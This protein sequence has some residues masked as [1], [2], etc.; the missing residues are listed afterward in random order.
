MKKIV[1]F[2]FVFLIMIPVLSIS[3]SAGGGGS[4]FVT[5][6]NYVYSD[7]FD[8]NTLSGGGT[9]LKT[10]SVDSKLLNSNNSLN[11]EKMLWAQA[12][13]SCSFDSKSYKE[14]ERSYCKDG[15][16]S[17]CF[18]PYAFMFD[19]V[20]T[21]TAYLFEFHNDYVRFLSALYANNYNGFKIYADGKPF[22]YLAFNYRTTSKS[23][24]R[25]RYNYFTCVYYS[26][27]KFSL[28]KKDDYYT[29]ENPDTS[30]PVY[31]L[32]SSYREDLYTVNPDQKYTVSSPSR[33]LTIIKEKNFARF[34]QNNFSSIISTGSSSNISESDYLCTKE[35]FEVES[36]YSNFDFGEGLFSDCEVHCKGSV[37]N[38]NMFPGDL[39]NKIDVKFEPELKLNMD[40]LNE[41]DE[42]VKFTVTNH[43]DK[44]VQFCMYIDGMDNEDEYFSLTDAGTG[45][46]I[47]DK[48]K[49]LKKFAYQK[50]LWNYK[51]ENYYYELDVHDNSKLLGISVA[52]ELVPTKVQGST[53]WIYLK[54]NE[55]YSD[56]I[57][58]ANV[59]LA[60]GVKY[61]M[62][63]KAFEVPDTLDIATNIIYDS[64]VITD[65]RY[66]EGVVNGGLNRKPW[67]MPF[68]SSI[69]ANDKL[70][71]YMLSPDDLATVYQKEIS[72]VTIPEF[73]DT[74]IG[75]SGTLSNGYLN[76]I[77]EFSKYNYKKDLTTGVEEFGS[78]VSGGTQ[79][80]DIENVQ[81]GDVI[82]YL[83]YC[84]SFFVLLKAAFMC[85]PAYIWVM[86]YFGLTAVVVIGIVKAVL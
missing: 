44:A 12:L 36:I 52:N 43:S 29:F 18:S 84:V 74:V 46:I 55:S 33:G 31:Q 39:G 5:N 23:S 2:M 22:Y 35:G 53:V 1:S 63:V 37:S 73:T 24:D 81:K 4:G 70:S 17:K 15:D 54:P 20:T 79:E 25:L 47:V 57:Y 59:N 19:N 72:F 58:W 7:M 27:S 48:E 80:I 83:K 11:I 8:S 77:D 68:L 62:N 9:V 3:V 56:V 30:N 14:W 38:A 45:A 85:F 26:K 49:Y 6:A 40:V 32:T 50:A 21:N 10:D 41:D 75:G 61:R 67:T 34:R 82:S 86:L 51:R 28:V 66:L 78:S 71:N 69:K 64:N 60:R 65:R 76:D 16:T 42:R 13:D